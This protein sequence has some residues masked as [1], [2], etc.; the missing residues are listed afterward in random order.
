MVSYILQHFEEYEMYGKGS[1]NSVRLWHY[2]YMRA[3]KDT[4]CVTSL[5]LNTHMSHICQGKI[6]PYSP[7]PTLY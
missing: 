4:W 5:R 2:K 6:Q 3:H 1:R 7:T